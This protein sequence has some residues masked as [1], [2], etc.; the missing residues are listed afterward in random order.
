[1]AERSNNN[2]HA[3]LSA[4]QAVQA[5]RESLPAL[6]GKEIESVLGV[7][8]DE[9]GWVVTVQVLE[10]HRIP[11]TT[12]VLGAYIATIDEGGD[13]TGYRRRRRYTRSQ[14]DDD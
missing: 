6:L 2:G 1:M 11:P 14:V 8:R 13:L 9:E 5:V 3:K 12:D 7:E 10:L 4:P